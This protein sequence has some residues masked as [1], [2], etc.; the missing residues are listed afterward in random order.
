MNVSA[1]VDSPQE[2]FDP[3][4]RR[5]IPVE[6]VKSFAKDELPRYVKRRPVVPGFRVDGLARGTGLVNSREKLVD[7]SVNDSFLLAKGRVGE[8]V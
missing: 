4:V 3:R 6:A 5:R 7:V 1:E 8:S 2:R